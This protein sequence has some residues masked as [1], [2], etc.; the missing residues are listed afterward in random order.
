MSLREIPHPAA[1]SFPNYARVRNL[2]SAYNGRRAAKRAGELLREMRERGERAERG[3]T[4]ES[5]GKTQLADLGITKQESSRYQQLA[6]ADLVILVRHLT[7]ESFSR[8]YAQT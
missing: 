8:R 6:E 7:H 2:Q 4:P 5:Q 1:V 3:N